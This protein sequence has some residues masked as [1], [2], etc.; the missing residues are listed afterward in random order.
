MQ[1]AFAAVWRNA[2]VRAL[3]TL[4]LFLAAFLFFVA[5]A[6]GLV[7]GRGRLF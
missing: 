2:Y 3:V 5:H 4:L 6:A 7:F 1:Q